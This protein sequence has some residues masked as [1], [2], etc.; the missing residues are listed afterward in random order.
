MGAGSSGIRA[1]APTPEQQ[2][3]EEESTTST[4][5]RSGIIVSS[6]DAMMCQNQAGGGLKGCAGLGSNVA[7]LEGTLMMVGAR[8][9]RNEYTEVVPL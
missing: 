8:G 7:R 9:G 4:A 6:H 2:R 5:T 3:R 1:P